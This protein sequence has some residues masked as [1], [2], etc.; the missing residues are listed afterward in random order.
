MLLR[1]CLMIVLAATAALSSAVAPAAADD[2]AT[3]ASCLKAEH[4]ANRDGHA[5]M[6]KVSD[7]CLEG[8]GSE[9]TTSMVACV[10]NEIKVWDDLLNADYQSLLQVVPEK[11]AESIRKAQ[12]AW[13]ALR[14]ADCR[15]AYDIYE[16]GTMAR[17]DSVSCVLRHT[18]ERVLQLRIWRQM[19]RPEEN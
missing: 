10:D 14:D 16:G 4:A 15:V 8:K 5:C 3:I 19:A 1:T 17:L 13:I 6:G 18:S 9:T 12:R 7:P 2:A 11:A